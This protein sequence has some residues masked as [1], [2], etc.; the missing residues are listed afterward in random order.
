MSF[1][2]HSYDQLDQ[3]AWQSL[4]SWEGAAPDS[5]AVWQLLSNV[6]L[7]GRFRDAVQASR[8]PFVQRLRRSTRLNILGA[9]AVPIERQKRWNSRFANLVS[10]RF[11]EILFSLAY[12]SPIEALGLTL[13]ATFDKRDWHDYLIE[14]D[15]GRFRVAINL[16][17]AGIQFRGAQQFVGMAPEDTLPIATYKIF[18]S[19]AKE[20]QLPLVYIYL[21]DWTLIPRLRVAYWDRLN[22]GER[23][24]FQLMT[25]FKGVPRDLEDRFI[26]ETVGER[27]DV[28][29]VGVDYDPRRLAALP[30]RAIS[31]ARCKAIFYRDHSRSPYVFRQ[32]MDTDPNVHVSVKGE[33]VQVSEFMDTWLASRRRREELLAGLRRTAAMRIPDPPV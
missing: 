32:R 20:E 8:H 12:R 17:N 18:G 31:G 25:T 10:G 24:V 19:S 3:P 6:E 2:L 5:D 27:M 9:G 30:F 16:K 23:R 26:E 7:P 29:C 33:T 28:L 14:G 13:L 11:T 15:E 21:V 4:T 22:P 1:V